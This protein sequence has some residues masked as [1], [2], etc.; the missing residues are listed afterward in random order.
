MKRMWWNENDIK[1]L[2]NGLVF[3]SLQQ[4]IVDIICIYNFFCLFFFVFFPQSID[5][6]FQSVADGDG[7]KYLPHHAAL[8]HS[9]T[10]TTM[11]VFSPQKATSP[12][13]PSIAKSCKNAMPSYTLADSLK[14][15]VIISIR[16][17]LSSRREEQCLTVHWWWCSP[18]INKV[19]VD[20]ILHDQWQT[21]ILHAF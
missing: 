16:F 11:C 15:T 17:L 7:L 19:S 20:I 1:W 13:P 8:A 5:N 4:L 2:V 18:Q 3:Q 14:A 10:N 6:L 12:A 21:H 9:F